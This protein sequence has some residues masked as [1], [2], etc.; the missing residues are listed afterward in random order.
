MIQHVT[1]AL[2]DEE[3]GRACALAERLGVPVEDYLRSLIL[4]Y[5]PQ[6][7]G[8]ARGSGGT[9]ENLFDLGKEGEPTDIGRDK[10]KMIGEAVWKEHLRKTRQTE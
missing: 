8:R 2:D 1:I 10:D 9:V 3:F 5:L 4:Q 6:P 7:E